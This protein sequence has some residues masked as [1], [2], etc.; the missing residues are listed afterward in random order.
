MSKDLIWGGIALWVVS[1]IIFLTDV[2]WV[3]LPQERSSGNGFL[4]I[5]A[6]A[7]TIA[8]LITEIY[9]KHLEFKE[10]EK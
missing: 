4:V 7:F 8:G 6:L 5:L 2:L 10:R 1:Q 3:G 9:D